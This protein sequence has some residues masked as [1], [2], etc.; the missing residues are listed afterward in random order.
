VLIYGQVEFQAFPAWCRLREV[1]LQRG[2]RFDSSLTLRVTSQG[3][4]F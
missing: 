3:M 1:R 4:N 2:D